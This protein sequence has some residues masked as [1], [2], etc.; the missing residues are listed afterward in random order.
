[1]SGIPI[2][3]RLPNGDSGNLARASWALVLARAME[4]AALRGKPPHEVSTEDW[5]QAAASLT[6]I[7]QARSLALAGDVSIRQSP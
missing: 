4:L 2:G 1:M 5:D 6:G 3:T 7:L